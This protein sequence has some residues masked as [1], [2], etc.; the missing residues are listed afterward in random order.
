MGYI[1]AF[2]GGIL[3]FLSPCVLPLVPVFIAYAS[4]IT[5]DELE[6]G[7]SKPFSRIFLNT[8]L[9]TAGFTAVFACLSALLFIFVQFL[10]SYKAWFN[11]AA[12]LVIVIFG[13]HMAGA[14]NIPFLNRQARLSP[15]VKKNSPM[16]SFI[17]G[18]AFGGGWTP[19]VGP[20]LSGI[21]FTSAAQRG[22]L[23]AVLLLVVYSMGL[24]VPFIL[25]GLFTGRLLSFF[26]GVKKHYRVVE[27]ISGLFLIALGVLLIFDLM[28]YISGAMSG[29][30]PWAG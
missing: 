3:T 22:P 23:P 10:G 27:I 2:T 24:G 30:F 8:I 13:L 7:K 16:S 20:V 5:A 11:R 29:I 21:L 28:G 25:T 14:V 6:A 15:D 1:I 19:C 17:M 9:F 12:G 4:G 18:A 26:R